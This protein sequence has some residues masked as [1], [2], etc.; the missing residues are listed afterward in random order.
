MEYRKNEPVRTRFR[1]HR[2]FRSDEMWYFHTREGIDVGPFSSEFEAQVEAS[3]LKNVLKSAAS[4]HGIAAIREFLLDARTPS[5][6]L[7]AS[8]T[9]SRR[10]GAS[11]RVITCDRR[12]IACTRDD[13]ARA[14][15]VRNVDHLTAKAERHAP[16]ALRMFERGDE[17]A[18][19]SHLVGDGVNSSFTIGIWSGMD[20]DLAR[21]AHP[22]AFLAV[23]P[24]S[25]E[26]LDVDVDGIERLN[27]TGGCAQQRLNATELEHIEVV[28]VVVAI[29]ARA[30]RSGQIFGAPRQRRH[31]RTL[32][33]C[34]QVEH[35]LRRFGRDKDQLHAPL[36]VPILGFERCQSPIDALDVGQR[37]D[38]GDE[39]R[40]RR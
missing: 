19:L 37:A 33:E 4:R 29:A 39:I 9:T 13:R 35:T 23:A 6:D 25:V 11:R 24:Q 15:Q 5:C 40:I 20:R 30:D 31:P 21:V 1:S 16:V 38:F 2:I 12:R 34:R 18:R 3:I 36:R 8:P 7:R 26:V 17:F 28:A 10:K 14:I 27:V 32:G 22:G